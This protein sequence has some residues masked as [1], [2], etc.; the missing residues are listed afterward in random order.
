MT[1]MSIRGLDEQVLA[2]LKAQAA[3]QGSSLNSLV[4]RLL[5]GT[6]S[7]QATPSRPPQT[8]DDLNALAGTWSP[9]DAA[10]FARNTAPFAEVDAT[11]WR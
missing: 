6:N 10:V 9:E 2:K 11:L 1:T 8:F 3:R 4:L 5:Q 7:D